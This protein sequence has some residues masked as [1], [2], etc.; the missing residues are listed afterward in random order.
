MNLNA[1]SP[2][3]TAHRRAHAR[4]RDMILLGELEPGQLM[5]TEAQLEKQL[6]VSRLTVRGA[7]A[8]LV[9]Q[10]LVDVQQGHGT[11]IK[12]WRRDGSFE[13]AGAML[14]MEQGSKGA[15]TPMDQLLWLRRNLYVGLAPLLCRP[16]VTLA[17]MELEVAGIRLLF[18]LH[19]PIPLKVLQTEEIALCVLAEISGL[20]AAGLFANSIRRAI[21][22]VARNGTAHYQAADSSKRFKELLEAL[23]GRKVAEVTQQI[24]ALCQLREDTYLKLATSKP[25]T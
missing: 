9:A 20:G 15:A 19:P 5:P 4:L 7:I 6:K 2:P 25:I 22:D 8:M 14:L 18:G 3:V 1:P 21:G 24:T 11:R 12:E 16:S 23:E 17:P 13:L 10:G